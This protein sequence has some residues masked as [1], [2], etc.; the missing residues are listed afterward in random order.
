MKRKKE[1]TQEEKKNLLKK[2]MKEDSFFKGNVLPTVV[3]IIV[4]TMI[5]FITHISNNGG[6]SNLDILS[7]D[8]HNIIRNESSIN[9]LD[10]TPNKLRNNDM[11]ISYNQDGKTIKGTSKLVF[12]EEYENSDN[13][14]EKISTQTYVI[15]ED[16]NSLNVEITEVTNS[17]YSLRVINYSN[18]DEYKLL[19]NF[20]R[21][22]DK[23]LSFVPNTKSDFLIRTEQNSSANFFEGE[24][25]EVLGLNAKITEVGAKEILNEKREYIRVDV[26]DDELEGY[27]IFAENLGLVSMVT[28]NSSRG[29]KLET[30]FNI[31]SII[32]SE[33]SLF[34]LDVEV[35]N[36]NT[37]EFE[38]KSVER[39]VNQTVNNLIINAINYIDD[40]IYLENLKVL[41]IENYFIE[42]GDVRLFKLE[43]NQ[44][45]NTITDEE[46][47]VI[48]ETY[49]RYYKYLSE[50][51]VYE[52]ELVD[53]NGESINY[54]ES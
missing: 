21:D 53:Y 32:P 6:I 38:V 48:A 26:V 44:D 28:G 24:K 5:I 7:G 19:Y 14:I 8:S 12:I 22:E 11:L 17:T 41:S 34:E 29:Q 49:I 23:L 2:R 45:V 54:R 3:I 39:E 30:I 35:F 40:G 27:L 4:L 13:E 1:N 31:E 43:V 18:T 20:I 37:K 46:L 10:L 50:Y 25:L 36:N 47:E 52:V 51:A 15:D 33:D 42:D 9:M 16:I